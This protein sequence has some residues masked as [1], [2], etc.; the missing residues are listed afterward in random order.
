MPYR[1]CCLTVCARRMH[2]KWQHPIYIIAFVHLFFCSVHAPN[3]SFG[4]SVVAMENGTVISVAADWL[5]DGVNNTLFG[6]ILN[7]YI[8][9]DCVM[10][11]VCVRSWYDLWD[12]RRTQPPICVCVRLRDRWL[13]LQ[14]ARNSYKCVKERLWIVMMLLLLLLRWCWCWWTLTPTCHWYIPRTIFVNKPQ[15]QSC[16]VFYCLKFVLLWIVFL[17]EQKYQ[18]HWNSIFESVISGICADD[19][20]LH[21][22]Y[23]MTMFGGEVQVKFLRKYGLQPINVQNVFHIKKM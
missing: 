13:I 5:L 1:R 23:M 22:S 8:Y 2:R 21:T 15:A 4:S 19:I 11:A 17:R 14:Y 9:I 6:W 3:R 18:F 16:F 12:A 20:C 7:I 10:C